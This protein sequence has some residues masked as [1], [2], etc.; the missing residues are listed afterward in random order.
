M[1][2]IE[3]DRTAAPRLGH[4]PRTH[5]R[6]RVSNGMVQATYDVIRHEQS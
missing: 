6:R 1:T 4:P 2:T 3:N 5:L